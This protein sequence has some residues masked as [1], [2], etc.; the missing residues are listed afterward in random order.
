M[1]GMDVEALVHPL[2][3]GAPCGTDLD[4]T[5]QMAAIDAFRVFGQDRP[6][7]TDT[8]W[9]AINAAALDALGTSRD[10]RLLAHLAAAQLR[11]AGLQ[12]FVGSL[13]VAARWLEDYFD[14]VFPRI[15]DDAVLRKNALNYF[16]DRMAV[17]DALRRVPLVSHRQLGSFNLRHVTIAAGQQAP[18]AE[19]A[20]SPPTEALING[21]FAAAPPEE[22]VQLVA[23][24]DAGL[25][26]LKTIE[27]AMVAKHGVQAA[28]DT[29]PLSEVLV[30]MRDIVAKHVP[31]PATA[32]AVDAAADGAAPADSVPGQIRSREDAIRSLDAVADFFRRC[33]PSSPVPM[34][35]ERAK[36]L[37]SRNFLE[38]LAELAPDSVAAVKHAGGIRDAE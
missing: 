28:P 4:D 34:F 22:L 20:V 29:G 17:I 38:V 24:I 11:L 3:E 32:A 33:E 14:D 9:R 12:P 1:A 25:S 26:A 2:G 5:Q 6:L 8:D 13:G 15:D 10:F 23:S 21:A 30:R 19:D 7:N 37:I 18:D 35:V 31:V 36:R 16:A 27:S